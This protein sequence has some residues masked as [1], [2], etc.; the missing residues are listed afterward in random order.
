MDQ[1]LFLDRDYV[2]FISLLSKSL[3]KINQLIFYCNS[4]E[5]LN[6]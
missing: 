1:F 6:S 5:Y 3:V 2:V 4:L